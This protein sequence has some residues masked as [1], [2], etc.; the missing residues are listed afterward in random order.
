M[1][2]ANNK[3]ILPMHIIE[4]TNLREIISESKIIKIDNVVLDES[5]VTIPDHFKAI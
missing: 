3:G 2:L 5:V 1:N 4:R